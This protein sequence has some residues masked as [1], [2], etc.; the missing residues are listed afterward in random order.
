MKTLGFRGTVLNIRIVAGDVSVVDEDV[1]GG[2]GGLRRLRAT[3]L[4]GCY[5]AVWARIA[6]SAVG[7]AK[8]PFRATNKPPFRRRTARFCRGTRSFGTRSFERKRAF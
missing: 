5:V 3:L 4:C 2:G 8:E 6:L 1:G 7:G